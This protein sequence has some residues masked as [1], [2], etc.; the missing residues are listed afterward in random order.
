MLCLQRFLTPAFNDGFIEVVGV[1]G[2]MHM[3]C[4][5]DVEC[6]CK[7]K[8]YVLYFRHKF[9]EVFGQAFG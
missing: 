1:N 2:V 3:V 4:L 8:V 7:V 5:L 9:R 6:R